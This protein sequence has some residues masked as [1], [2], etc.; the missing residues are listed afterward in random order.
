MGEKAA[1]LRGETGLTGMVRNRGR[2]FA[3]RVKRAA[4][5]PPGCGPGLKRLSLPSSSRVFRCE[6]TGV[7]VHFLAPA[8][9]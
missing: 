6:E 9:V 4:L 5:D 1:R 8:S 3:A 2:H 7:R